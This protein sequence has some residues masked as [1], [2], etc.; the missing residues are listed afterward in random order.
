MASTLKPGLQEIR[1]LPRWAILAFAARFARRVLPLYKV[2]EA[3]TIPAPA[4]RHALEVAE[5]SATKAAVQSG[6]YAY[7]GTIQAYEAF[8]FVTYDAL[9]PHDPS[10]CAR[11]A[12][13]GAIDAHAAIASGNIDLAALA[14]E[15]AAAAACLACA[16]IGKPD[17]ADAVATATERDFQLLRTSAKD[18]GW[19]D[20]TPVPPHYFPYNSIFDLDSLI[21]DRSI[22]DITSELNERFVDHCLRDPSRLHDLSPRKFEELV[23]KLFQEFG[24]DV[25]LTKAT[26]DGGKDIVA[27]KNN[28]TKLKYIIECKRYAPDNA[29]GIAVVQRLF[30]VVVLEG[31][32]KGLVVT[33][34]RF[35]KPAMETVNQANATQWRLD[36]TDFEGLTKWLQL[37]QNLQM[38]RTLGL[39]LS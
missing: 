35:T 18:N 29:V 8:R 38:Y 37:Y 15:G 27:I 31:A 22:M 34:S 36:A 19:T 13:T 39:G 7:G 33:T 20:S 2:T 32:D 6:I 26:R 25:E 11:A 14:A 5:R 10:S 1:Q 12:V 17:R 9:N 3:E 21:D 30:G 24:F 28:S 16:A 23:A 4:V